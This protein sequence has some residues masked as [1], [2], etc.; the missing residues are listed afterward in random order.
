M[1]LNSERICN[2]V[3]A[4]QFRER[5]TAGGIKLRTAGVPKQT[6]QHTMLLLYYQYSAALV[7]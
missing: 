7:G 3:N 1:R 6:L 2:L 4:S 5:Y